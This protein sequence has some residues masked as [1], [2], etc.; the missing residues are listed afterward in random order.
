MRQCEVGQA[1]SAEPERRAADDA[2]HRA[3]RRAAASAAASLV[4]RRHEGARVRQVGRIDAAVGRRRV[5]AERR[6]RSASTAAAA[7]AADWRGARR[8]AAEAR[9][10]RRRREQIG[11]VLAQQPLLV[12]EVSDAL[13]GVLVVLVHEHEAARATPAAN[14]VRVGPSRVAVA[15]LHLDASLRI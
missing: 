13:N 2:V 3:R 7:A 14:A 4:R 1:R 12:L 9:R 10:R 11:S 8:R 15:A 5:A 6:R